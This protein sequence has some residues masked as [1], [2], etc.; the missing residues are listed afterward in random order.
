MG[1]L[2]IDIAAV[3]AFLGFN[4]ALA[5]ATARSRR[6]LNA[7]LGKYDAMQDAQCLEEF[8]RIARWNMRMALCF[9]SLGAV[10]IAMA[11]Y[12]A[13][14]FGPAGMGLVLLVSVPGFYMGQSTKAIELRARSLA[15]SDPELQAEYSRVSTSWVKKLLADF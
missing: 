11:I 9:L 15:C 8:K 5:V 13:N 10:S 1:T 3:V 6:D 14:E 12:L 4:A 7:F 2:S